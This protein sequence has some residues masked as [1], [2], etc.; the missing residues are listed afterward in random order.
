MHTHTQHFRMNSFVSFKKLC[1]FSCLKM[2]HAKN[3]TIS[4]DV[5]CTTPP[6]RS[7][8]RST[9]EW[10]L[11][12][13]VDICYLCW[14]ANAN[15]LYRTWRNL[16]FYTLSLSPSSLSVSSSLNICI[17]LSLFIQAHIVCYSLNS[18][19]QHVRMKTEICSSY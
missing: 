8:I 19:A 17:Y 7:P 10:I 15:L 14:N 2:L 4:G 1:K 3:T 9:F 6:I 18:V 13:P 5:N 16:I 12:F 11:P